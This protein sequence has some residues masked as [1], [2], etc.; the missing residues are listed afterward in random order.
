MTIAINTTTV[1]ANMLDDYSYFLQEVII[2]LIE[3]N[4]SAQFV[5]I[6]DNTAITLPQKYKNVRSLILKPSITSPLILKYWYAI[7]LP[8][9]LNKIKPDVMLQTAGYC[10]NTTKYKQV[11]LM[12]HNHFGNYPSKLVGKKT[13]AT[14]AHIICVGNALHNQVNQQYTASTNKTSVVNGAAHYLY[15]P[16]THDQSLLIKDGYADGRE[17]FFTIQDMYS[18]DNMVALLKAFSL[19]K[20]WQHSTMKL[21]IADKLANSFLQEKLHNYKYKD[22]VVVVANIT[23]DKLA[24]L[25]ASAYCVIDGSRY[26]AYSAN[27]FNAMQTC[28]PVIT[29]KTFNNNLPVA[30]NTNVHDTVELSNSMKHIYKDEKFRSELIANASK[31]VSNFSWDKTASEI[32]KLIV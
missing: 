16:L 3:K 2:S 14:A 30:I 24:K 11:L 19:F 17:Y 32:M 15:K 25:T 10:S 9:E 12:L 18:S 28:V 26:N 22:D 29:Q 4:P 8:L 27:I 7:K 21:V 6:S 23:E 31:F 20:K 5:L 13:I 1:Q